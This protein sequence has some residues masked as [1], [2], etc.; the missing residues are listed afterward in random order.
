MSSTIASE[1][2]VEK[3][4][5]GNLN[6]YLFLS[7]YLVYIVIQFMRSINTTLIISDKVKYA[8]LIPLILMV[9]MNRYTSKSLLINLG[10]LSITTI[11][12]I[13]SETYTD[14]ILI[15]LFIF[16]S[17]F[18]PFE[19]IVKI[20]FYVLSGLVVLVFILYN[21]GLLKEIDYY[22]YIREGKVRHSLGYLYTTFM[23]NFFLHLVLM[24]A[25]IR[26]KFRILELVVILLINQYL[27]EM[28]Q[29]QA[30]YYY[31]LLLVFAS[32]MY[33]NFNLYKLL[34]NGIR[35]L[36]LFISF[37]FF[38]VF[39]AYAS[40][41]Y[42]PNKNWLYELNSILTGRLNLGNEGFEKYGL[43]L[44]GQPIEWIVLE[45]SVLLNEYF[46]VDSSSLNMLLNYGILLTFIILVLFYIASRRLIITNARPIFFIVVIILLLHSA[47]DPQ[48]FELRYNP[49][50]FL[51]GGLI[52]P[53]REE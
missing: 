26:E 10:L 8:L 27:Y 43:S 45:K 33:I 17:S 39:P 11:V 13:V 36:A 3:E 25:F 19:K 16:C 18:I 29:T 5:I 50:L 47:F 31:V 1:A 2:S 9:V 4:K 46:Y 12:S 44:F 7:A 6:T 28:T 20:H 22:N 40:Y 51:I 48:F 42:D 52:N 41:I 21:I 38:A 49:F 24:Y 53:N 14:L 34:G 35:K 15:Y 32:F 30:V 37:S 23:P